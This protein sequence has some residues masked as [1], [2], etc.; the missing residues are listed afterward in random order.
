[1]EGPRGR[2]GF[3]KQWKHVRRELDSRGSVSWHQFF[4]QKYLVESEKSLRFRLQ[5]AQLRFLFTC[6]IGIYFSLFLQIIFDGSVVVFF[7]YMNCANSDAA[8]LCFLVSC[9]ERVLDIGR[10]PVA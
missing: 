7:F 6:N 5:L 10:T 1:M 2:R 4:F 3:L 8:D 9:L